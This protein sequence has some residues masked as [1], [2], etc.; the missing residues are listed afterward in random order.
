V[1]LREED[2]QPQT[3]LM[4]QVENEVGYLGPGRDRSAEANRLFHGPVP[5]TL[6]RSLREKR[7]QASPELATHFDE[8][9]KSWSDVFGDAAGEAF[10]AWNCATYIEAVGGAGK[11]E[12]ALPMY[13]NAQLPAPQE[14]PGEY[15]SG[16]PHPAYL[17]VW[18]TAAPSIDFYSP[19]IYWPN[20]EHWT[21]RY[22]I[23]GNAIF[24]P[25]ARMESAAYNALYAYGAS[26]RLRL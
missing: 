19:D 23:P 9:G 21:Q 7:L 26:A 25:E 13:V 22:E 1:H 10:M 2:S 15:P 4:V 3:V 5:N 8:Q 12:Y 20:F 11:H 14:R 6:L 18:R 17:E 24:I 16:G